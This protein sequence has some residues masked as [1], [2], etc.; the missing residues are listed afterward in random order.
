LSVERSAPRGAVFL[1]YASQDAE[2]AKRIADALRGAGVEV[3]FDQNELVGGDAWDQKIRKQIGSCALFV[4]IVSANTQARGEGYFRIE[5]RLAAQRTH[6]M[7][8]D[9]TFLLPVVIDAT[10][11]AEARVPAEFKQVQWTR[12]PGGQPTPAFGARVCRLLQDCRDHGGVQQSAPA[13]AAP[14]RSRPR[15]WRWLG[16]G[17]SALALTLF[18]LRFWW[19]SWMRDAAAPVSVSAPSEARKLAAQAS[20]LLQEPNLT[21]ESSWLAD[22]LGEKALRLDASDPEAWAVASLASL[23]LYANIY[24]T[25]A[26]RREKARMQAE[27]A[28]QLDPQSIHAGLAVARYQL[29]FG[30]QDEAWRMLEKLHARAADDQPVLFSLIEVARRRDDD[31]AVAGYF[32]ELRA[33]PRSGVLAQALWF[34]AVRLRGGGRFAEAEKL[35]DEVLAEMGPLRGALYE[36]LLLVTCGW[37]EL[38]EGEAIIARLPERFRQEPAFGSELAQ[39]WLMRGAAGEALEALGRVP[40]EYL[41]EFIAREPRALLAGWAHSL[42]GR[43]AAA[44]AEWQSALSVVEAKLKEDP[45]NPALLHQRV[46]LLGLTGQKDAA[47]AA[48]QPLSELTDGRTSIGTGN[49]VQILSVLGDTDAAV[50][51]AERLWPTLEAGQKARFLNQLNHHPAYSPLRDLSRVRAIREEGARWL[52]GLKPAATPNESGA[53]APTTAAK[54][55]AVLAFANLS[56]DKTNEYFS[57]GISE[58]LLNVLAKVPGLKVSARTSAFYFKGK[59]VPIPEIAQK[60]GVAYVI[61]GSVRKAGDKVRITAQL[62]KAADGFHVWS[63][64]FTRDLKDIFAVQDEIAGLIAQRLKLAVTGQANRTATV[65]AEAFEL[66]LRGRQAWALR[67]RASLVRAEQCF[68]DALALQPDFARAMVGLA[69][70]WINQGDYGQLPAFKN[71][72]APEWDRILEKLTDALALDPNSAEAVASLANATNYRWDF[73]KAD[74]LYRRAIELNPN[75]ASAHQWYARHLALMGRM[76]EALRQID[77]ALACDPFAP[78][79]V[80]N[81]AMIYV[82]AGRPAQGLELAERSLALQQNN[83]QA[84]VWKSEAL[85]A[86]GRKQ[87]LADLVHA[88][89][90]AAGSANQLNGL[91]YLIQ[92]GLAAPSEAD[93]AAFR[94]FN[95]NT[96]GTSDYARVRYNLVLDQPAEALAVLQ[97][98]EASYALCEW[99][100]YLPL[101]D[102]IRSEPAFRRFYESVGMLAAHDRAQAWRA[103]QGLIKSDQKK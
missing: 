34:E 98:A 68:R 13:V 42:A 50:E 37:H 73:E 33:L 26:A 87:E 96:D 63:E 48:W 65:N 14:S 21:R 94:R 32:K 1:S 53:A 92:T 43:S 16:F 91:S 79:L 3:W 35:L 52:R 47:K 28:L 22:E 93:R 56:D 69:D 71:R 59:D 41:E 38:A 51:V 99:M 86:L 70:V 64:T 77:L 36:K 19:P 40:Q 24:D 5:W 46:L 72:Q 30:S 82:M 74:Q 17:L 75:Y 78:R 85:V 23:N 55:V 18:G 62:I 58:E 6:A 31:K 39:Y 66:Y 15:P 8:D 83:G 101:F 7:A 95:G 80:S 49:A 100:M 89:K 90:D 67:D 4:P 25:S 9:E 84:L 54:S 57:D 61:E 81:A 10:G 102:R 11:D 12:L 45:R 29:L 44:K 88:P 103:A 97:P 2:A 27:R 60:L 76:D 20:Q